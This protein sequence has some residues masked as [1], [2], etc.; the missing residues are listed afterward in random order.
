MK[1]WNEASASQPAWLNSPAQRVH[2]DGI[3]LGADLAPEG[4]DSLLVSRSERH[5]DSLVVDAEAV[6][7]IDWYR[8]YIQNWAW[9]HLGHHPR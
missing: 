7:M 4:D 9:T 5:V 3:S 6:Q 8:I 1:N 2:A